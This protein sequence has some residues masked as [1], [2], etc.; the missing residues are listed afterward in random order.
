VILSKTMMNIFSKWLQQFLKVF[1]DDLNIHN[2]TQED[3]F[4]HIHMVLKCLK[5]VNL[6]FNPNKCVF[7]QEH[8]DFGTCG[9]E[10]RNS[11]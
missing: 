1:V 5:D 3:H 2:I 11:T 10:G 6:K 4:N 8:Q 9:W 7:C